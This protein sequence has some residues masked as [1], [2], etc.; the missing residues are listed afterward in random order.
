MEPEA[1][2]AQQ[3]PWPPRRPRHPARPVRWR[4]L[5]PVASQADPGR[6]EPLRERL[7]L[8]VLLVLPGLAGP[9]VRVGLPDL[10]A[11]PALPGPAGLPEPPKQHPS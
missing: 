1:E 11:L 3:E 6:T 2:R 5:E 10:V 4:A 7:V 9:L 8:L